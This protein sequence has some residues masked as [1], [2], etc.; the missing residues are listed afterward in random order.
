MSLQ[1]VVQHVSY[2]TTP[3]GQPT[4]VQVQI[5]VWEQIV[6]VLSDAL[7]PK[8]VIS[9]QDAAWDL[10]LTMADDAQPGALVNPSTQH[11]NYL[12]G[13]VV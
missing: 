5:E 13:Q 1:E 2:V 8:E 4:A 6:A 3:G 7:A 12:Y 11:D 10:F 9:D